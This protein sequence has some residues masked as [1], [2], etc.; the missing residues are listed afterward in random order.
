MQPLRHALRGGAPPH[1]GA[2]QQTRAFRR[3]VG[4][5]GRAYAGAKAQQAAVLCF[6]IALLSALS[7]YAYGPGGS[8]K[9]SLLGS[10]GLHVICMALATL[11]ANSWILSATRGDLRSSTTGRG[12]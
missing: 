3:R 1:P 9:A 5:E 8:P 7:M 10:Y 11:D 12:P 4:R 2:D 6:R